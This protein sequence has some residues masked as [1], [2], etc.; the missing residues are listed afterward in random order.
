VRSDER[1]RM[2]SLAQDLPSGSAVAH[3]PSGQ[4]THDELAGLEAEFD[5]VD[6]SNAII[7]QDQQARFGTPYRSLRDIL[8]G[9]QT[10]IVEAPGKF[11]PARDA[12]TLAAEEKRQAST[13]SDRRRHW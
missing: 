3:K 8:S 9:T 1:Q 13:G 2:L 6:I 10:P 11:Q 7:L 5:Q 4:R 12:P